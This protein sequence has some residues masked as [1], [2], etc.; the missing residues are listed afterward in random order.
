MKSIAIRRPNSSPATRVNLLIMEQA[1]RIAR[2]KSKMAV[3]TQTLM[4]KINNEE[5]E[6]WWGVEKGNGS[7]HA[8]HAKKS[9]GPSSGL[10]LAKLYMNVYISTVGSATPRIKRGCPPMIECIIPHNEVEARV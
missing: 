8:V 10:S 4:M 9:F 6:I 2:R 5:Y 1:P 7:Y 3:Q